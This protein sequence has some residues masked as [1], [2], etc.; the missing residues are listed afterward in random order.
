MTT[1]TLYRGHK[2][3]HIGDYLAEKVKKFAK[4]LWEV[5]VDF[6]VARAASQLAHHG[7]TV[8]AKRLMMDHHK[9]KS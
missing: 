7:Y 6:G 5:G 3:P 8:E 9:N 4:G 2:L 1:T